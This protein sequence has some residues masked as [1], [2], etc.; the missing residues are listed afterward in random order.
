LP[1]QKTRY[2]GSTYSSSSNAK[3]VEEETEKVAEANAEANVAE[4]NA[5]KVEEANVTHLGV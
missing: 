3:K 5:E 4:A 2:P 1:T